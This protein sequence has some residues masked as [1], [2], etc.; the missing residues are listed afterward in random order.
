ML[1]CVRG[2]CD[3]CDRMGGSAGCCRLLATTFL[4]LAGLQAVRSVAV[5]SVDIGAEWMKVA[6]VSVGAALIIIVIY[7]IYWHVLSHLL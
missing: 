3:H 2:S 1:I 7:R 6:V 5:M 4:F